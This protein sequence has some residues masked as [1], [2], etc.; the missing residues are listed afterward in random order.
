MPLSTR[1]DSPSSPSLPPTSPLLPPPSPSPSVSSLDGGGEGRE[2]L[3]S[4]NTTMFTSPS[5]A[6]TAFQRSFD[7]AMRE[8]SASPLA[9]LPSSSSVSSL[10]SLAS[11][12]GSAT[13]MMR[14]QPSL[15]GL[16]AAD[17]A[18]IRE[19]VSSVTAAVRNTQGN[20][21]GSRPPSASGVGH[22]QYHSH[23]Q[24]ARTQRRSLSEAAS[25]AFDASYEAM[26]AK[27]LSR[28]ARTL[29]SPP[30][31][32]S[33]LDQSMR[34]TS[35]D[36]YHHHHHPQRHL[37]LAGSAPHH[38]AGLLTASDSTELLRRLCPPGADAST[39]A[40]TAPMMTWVATRSFSFCADSV[41]GRPLPVTVVPVAAA[42]M[43]RLT[44]P[45]LP[46]RSNA[47]SPPDTGMG[48]IAWRACLCGV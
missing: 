19:V 27:A 29:S 16:S 17:L 40:A 7:M 12:A 33:L 38:H 25:A 26:L 18:D 28:Q 44:S 6:H 42:P 46:P 24:Q 2:R 13:A 48:T 3:R 43:Q 32:P 47:A 21:G 31:S 35:K 37:S 11:S 5:R 36:S 14:P 10:S 23:Q 4:P 9:S 1:R 39:P 15:R 41:P 30:L 22:H 20:E 34:S 8:A 45:P